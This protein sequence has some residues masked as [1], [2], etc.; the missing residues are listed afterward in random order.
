[1]PS[2]FLLKGERE[3]LILNFIKKQ[4]LSA[5]CSAEGALKF[6]ETPFMPTAQ[7][8]AA[9]SSVSPIENR[10]FLWENS[11]REMQE[12]YLE[13]KIVPRKNNVYNRKGKV[14]A[15]D[16]IHSNF[17]H[18]DRTMRRR[19]RARR[20]YTSGYKGRATATERLRTIAL[21]LLVLV[22]LGAI[23]L[24]WGRKYVV[25]TEEGSRLEL[26]FFH[27]ESQTQPQEDEPQ[28]SEQAQPAQSQ[29]E[30]EPKTDKPVQA[31]S[32]TEGWL[33]A[34][35]LP[36]ESV[37]QG[38]LIS[39]VRESGANAVIL[40]MKTDQGTLGFVSQQPLALEAQA[41][42]PDSQ[43]N[44]RLKGLGEQSVYLIARISCF[45]D[46]ALTEN[47]AYAIQTK[48]G[49]RWMDWSEV[50]W[51]S[52][53]NQ[54]VRDYLTGLMVELAEMGFDEILLDNWGYPTREQGELD[55]IK[56]GAAYDAE[57]LDETITQFL[58]QAQQALEG[59]PVRL[60]VLTSQAVI[61]GEES[62]SGQTP[63]QLKELCDRIWVEQ[64][65]EVDELQMLAQAGIEEPEERL[66]ELVK[67][68]EQEK[69]GHQGLY[70]QS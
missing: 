20:T 52:P 39:Q 19:R 18:G 46:Q 54:A 69:E 59:Y 70:T 62:E 30:E 45:R 17:D 49:R 29:P 26:P 21:I 32:A 57:H 2:A 37:E 44:R 36:L 1:M 47:S 55:Y 11:M 35:Q 3:I 6:Y 38:A 31:Q 61:Q 4:V 40:D 67:Q 43:I 63:E 9:S 14:Q 53:Y 65:G 8:G 12:K 24:F 7:M 5:F 56:P 50:R 34:V 51:S 58:Q 33:R 41:N 15:V 10:Y 28:P 23:G 27:R 25:Q 22:V 64:E 66:V 16:S 42:W 68:F 13:K 60:S 48:P